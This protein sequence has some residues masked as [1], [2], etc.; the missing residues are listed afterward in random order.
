MTALWASL[1][2]SSVPHNAHFYHEVVKCLSRCVIADPMSLLPTAM[3]YTC[4]AF[5]LYGCTPSVSSNRDCVLY[6]LQYFHSSVLLPFCIQFYDGRS[7]SSSYP[8]LP[9]L[10]KADGE[11][12]NGFRDCDID[13]S[14]SQV[15][16]AAK[17]TRERPKPPE[18]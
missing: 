11:A 13:V 3:G 2:I 8:I 7:L 4:A 10:P 6:V 14:G 9:H 12:H 16:L 15:Q 17:G 18:H 5:L 1:G